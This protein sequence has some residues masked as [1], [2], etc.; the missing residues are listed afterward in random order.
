MIQ[1]I[2]ILI[3]L[4]LVSGTIFAGK[5]TIEKSSSVIR[6]DLFDE[7]RERAEDYKRREKERNQQN[8]VWSS[9]IDPSC[10]L[11]RNTYLIYMCGNGRYFKGYETNGNVE[12]RELSTAEVKKLNDENSNSK[13]T[14]K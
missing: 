1:K 13:N 12:Y 9:S 14:K 11:W 8:E 2:L 6:N 7:K 10:G 5:V 3:L 4:F